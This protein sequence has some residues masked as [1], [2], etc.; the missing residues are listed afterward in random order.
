MGEKSFQCN[1]DF[2]QHCSKS[3]ANALELSQP[4]NNLAGVISFMF[5]F[6]FLQSAA[7]GKGGQTI[8]Q[9][10]IEAKQE[11][12]NTFQTELALKIAIRSRE[13]DLESV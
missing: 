6:F 4:W 13:E 8:R 9:I 7:L 5:F 12:M 2:A 1:E 3:I 11:L 10:A